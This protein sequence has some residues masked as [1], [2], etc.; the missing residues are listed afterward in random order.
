ML[1]II[2]NTNQKKSSVFRNFFDNLQFLLLYNIRKRLTTKPALISC[3]YYL[4]K[5]IS[6]LDILSI[7]SIKLR[8]LF[9]TCLALICFSLES[10]SI[11]LP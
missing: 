4:S 8:F 10:L 11:I 1:Y 3:F 6:S 9:E 7:D 5:S 2:Y